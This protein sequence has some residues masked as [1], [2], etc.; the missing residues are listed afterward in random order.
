MISTDREQQ[1][2]EMIHRTFAREHSLLAGRKV[3]LFGS[4]ATGQA[5][6]RSDFDIGIDGDSPLD[7]VSFQRLVDQ[8]DRIDTLYRIDLVD[9]Q[10]VSEKFRRTAMKQAKV[11]YE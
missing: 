6:P 3:V 9:M 8:L 5:R 4:R 11:I 10:T 7:A 1:I 2:L